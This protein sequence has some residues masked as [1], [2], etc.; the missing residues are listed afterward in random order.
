MK[1]VIKGNKDS[2]STKSVGLKI[3]HRAVITLVGV[4]MKR[5]LLLI[6]ALWF[7]I[8]MC[9]AGTSFADWWTTEFKVWVATQDGCAGSVTKNNTDGTTNALNSNMTYWYWTNYS[10]TVSLTPTV[11]AGNS[12]TVCGWSESCLNDPANC[13]VVKPIHNY[14]PLH[15]A[16][17]SWQY[18]ITS[19]TTS[20]PNK[21]YYEILFQKCA[22]Q[23]FINNDWL[24]NYPTSTI[25]VGSS[26]GQNMVAA[27]GSLYGCDDIS[28]A[29]VSS[30][31]SWLTIT[32]S[33]NTSPGTPIYYTVG[34]NNTSS[35]RTATISFVGYSNS[36]TS[37]TSTLKVT[38]SAG[39]ACNYTLPSTSNSVSSGIGSYQF[40][41]NASASSCT[42]T[43]SS[44]ASWI[45]IGLGQSGTGSGTVVN[46]HPNM[47][48]FWSLKNVPVWEPPKGLVIRLAAIMPP[49]ASPDSP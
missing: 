3:A 35:A 18:T 45:T 28:S 16:E 13:F 22:W 36:F 4:I 8:S 25:Q 31:S 19:G 47:Y 23:F 21:Y 49:D 14:T 26:G 33:Y 44:D 42:W 46:G 2:L 10:Y 24:D 38:Q 15:S 5:R 39:A 40:S 11:D 43:A 30:D 32:S 34:A 1:D 7:V 48:H 27:H 29:T 17:T 20:N 9:M 6:M 12:T 41:V 37:A